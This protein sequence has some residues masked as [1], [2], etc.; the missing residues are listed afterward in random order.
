L[1]AQSTESLPIGQGSVLDKDR[2]GNALAW[3]LKAKE[4]KKKDVSADIND[5]RRRHDPLYFE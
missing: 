3:E 4:L 1:L 2:Q 5:W